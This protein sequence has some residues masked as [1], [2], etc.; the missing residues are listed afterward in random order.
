MRRFAVAL[1]FCALAPCAGAQD[2]VCEPVEPARVEN[3]DG[4]V[5]T[6]RTECPSPGLRRHIAEL[7]CDA[8]HSCDR[9]EV[10]Q[11][12]AYTPMGNAGLVDVDGDGLHEVEIRGACGAGPNCE[13]DIYRIDP[14]T[15]TLQ[16]FF[17]GGYYELQFIDGWLVQA[18]RSSCCSWN[19]LMWKLDAVHSLPLD[20]G[21]RHLRAQVD[22]S[23][24]TYDED[25]RGD[26]QCTFLRES[27][28]NRVVVAPP[29]PG[30]EDMICRH[31]GEAYRLTPPDTTPGAP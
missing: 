22:G 19:Y 10:D 26:A 17:S 16:H 14:A 23:G 25:G 12:T 27:G 7:T 9:L 15:R 28:D 29:S 3:R 30:L 5:L 13:G 31:Y 18:G 2:A 11:E 8:G 24:A 6:V 21:N 20:D 1:F 4:S